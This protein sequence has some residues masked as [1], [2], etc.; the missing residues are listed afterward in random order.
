MTRLPTL[1]RAGRTSVSSG[2]RLAGWAQ[3]LDPPGPECPRERSLAHLGGIAAAGTLLVYLL[4]RTAVTLPAGGLPLAAGLLLVLFEAV[5]LAVL[6]RRLVTVWDVDTTAP[7]PVPEAVEGRRCAVLIATRDEPAEVLAPTV[8]AACQLAPVHQTWVLDDG[9]RP[10]V[11][12][13]CAAYGARHVVAA[14]GRAD[15]ALAVGLLQ[16]EAA[17]GAAPVD[18]VALLEADQLPLPGFLS[19]T[20]GWFDDPAVG[21]VQGPRSCYNAGAYD[22]DGGTGEQGELA[23]VLP[24]RSR[25]GPGPLW[26]GAPALARVAA[27]QDAGAAGRPGALGLS[28]ALALSRRGWRTAYHHQTV[29]VG[30]GPTTPGEYLRQR[31]TAALAAMQ[32]LLSE[33]LWRAKR[34]LTWSAYL[35]YLGRTVGWLAGVGAVLGFAVPALVLLSGSPAVDA[36]PPVL[37]AAFLLTGLV[38]VW[39]GWLLHRGQ[40]QWRTSAA[41][42]VV[43]IPVGLSCLWWLLTRRPL[44]FGVSAPPDEQGR[45]CGRAPAV[46]WGLLVAAGAGVLYA[47]VAAVGGLP[48][49]AAAPAALLCGLWLLVAVVMLALGIRR[50]G[51]ATYATSRRNAYRVP[52]C[53]PVSVNG[54]RGELVDLSVAG[55]AAWL[56]HGVLTAETTIRLRLPASSELSLQTVRVSQGDDV[57]EISMRVAPGDWA[58]HRVLA[59]WLFHTPPGVVD[60]LPPGA[61]AVAAVAP[62]GRS[63]RPVLVRQHDDPPPVGLVGSGASPR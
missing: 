27:L 61:P 40:R 18:V 5:P 26:R 36:A 50:I 1:V 59:L 62:A 2:A 46:L 41:L 44:L 42:A 53:A 47:L 48:T 33:G 11:A 58:T 24:G 4:W 32:A 25:S 45:A 35:E 37:L 51:S 63:R 9:G 12:D 7:A 19:A 21:V 16:R 49:R 13:L 34:S 39:G 55:A 14:D 30:L 3:L 38:R 6:V 22:D 56:P 10:W 28:T 8:A 15:L 43:S 54:V 20:L 29:A 60:G 31:Q 17:A 57:D 52:V 23:L